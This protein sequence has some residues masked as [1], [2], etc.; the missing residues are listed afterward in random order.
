MSHRT[1][2]VVHAAKHVLEHGTRHG[3]TNL[4]VVGGTIATVAAAIGAAP[5]A[6]LLGGAAVAV[7]IAAALDSL[8]EKH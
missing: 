1:H 4:P 6:V 8:D 5:L 3:A 7:G 2:H